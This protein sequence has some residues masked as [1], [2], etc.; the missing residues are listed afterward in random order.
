MTL[1]FGTKTFIQVFFHH[2]ILLYIAV[3]NP[4]MSPEMLTYV[5]L[6]FY[7]TGFVLTVTKGSKKDTFSYFMLF[8]LLILV[9]AG[10][11][12]LLLGK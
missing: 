1:N 8:V 5:T 12:K 2:C 3:Y 10:I 6:L 11:Q 4:K 9:L 7:A